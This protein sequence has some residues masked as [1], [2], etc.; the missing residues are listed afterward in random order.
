VQGSESAEITRGE[1]CKSGLALG[2][3]SI[4][5]D[6]LVRIG[7]A[8]KDYQQGNRFLELPLMQKV[9]AEIL[10]TDCSE[11]ISL[12]KEILVSMVDGTLPATNEQIATYIAKLRELK[13]EQEEFNETQEVLAAV[14]T[15]VASSLDGVI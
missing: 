3:F 1:V 15:K 9:T 7:G 11:R 2:V 5:G 12:T 6:A 14:G 8:G 10:M 4:G 13:L